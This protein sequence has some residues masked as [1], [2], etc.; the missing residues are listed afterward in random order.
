MSELNLEWL[1]K[2][3]NYSDSIFI[4][5][6]CADIGSDTLRFKVAIPNAKIYAFDAANI[7]KDKN[8]KTA[9]LFELNYIHKAVSYYDGTANFY[10]GDYTANDYWE[11]RGRLID[12][13]I[14]KD[15]RNWHKEV[16]GVISLNTFCKQNNI[17][18]SFLHIDTEG[19]EYNILK[20]LEEAFWPQA[21]WLEHWDHYH[22]NKD[23]FV[24]FNTLNELLLKRNYRQLYIKHD[25]LYVKNT[26]KVSNYVE[27]NSSCDFEK[28]IINNIWLIKYNLIKGDSW[29]I[30]NHINEYKSLPDNIIKEA[31]TDFN[32]YPFA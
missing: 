22:S 7:W 21:I 31:E 14:Q 23:E 12:P 18:P 3:F 30:I 25:V 8:L 13:K 11:Y 24:D 16:T 19:E 6:G 5:I 10:A 26:Y 1:N 29:P 27:Y 2:N 15:I 20:N 17:I 4:E 32:F 28:E 9:N